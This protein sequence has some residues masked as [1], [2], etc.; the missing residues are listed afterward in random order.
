[1]TGRELVWRAA[2]FQCP[3][4]VPYDLLAPFE[5]DFLWVKTTAPAQWMPAQ[6][7]EDE[8]GCIWAS[9][10]QGKSQGYVVHYPLADYAFLTRYQFPNFSLPERYELARQ[11]IADNKEKRFVVANTR[12]SFFE[13]LAIMRGL[14]NLL[15]DIYEHPQEMH[16]VLRRLLELQCEAIHRLAD[17]GVDGVFWC[18]DLGMQDRCFV[19]PDI[20]REH[21]EPYYRAAFDLAHKRGLL[22]L[23]HSCGHIM[24]LLEHLIDAGLDLIQL[25]QVEN[26]GIDNLARR[27]GGRICFWCPVDIQGVMVHGSPDQVRDQARHMMWALGN[28]DGGFIGKCFWMPDA[29][30]HRPENIAAMARSLVE[31]GKYPLKINL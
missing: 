11:R 7:G 24:D 20:F 16:C 3:E 1:M 29:L 26:M 31:D 30:G 13:R 9:P 17:L 28:Y 19:S 25:D 15:L 2:R 12:I 23:M 6:K 4:R 21:F 27:F 18:D 22:T 5:S 14:D 10:D 8:W